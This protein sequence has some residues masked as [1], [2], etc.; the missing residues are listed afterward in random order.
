MPYLF[1]IG[2]A[3][4]LCLAEAQVFANRHSAQLTKISDQLCQIDLSQKQVESIGVQSG[5]IVKIA[6]IIN[7]DSSSPSEDI[8]ADL[9]K[10]AHKANFAVISPRQSIS[11]QSIKN[12][13]KAQNIS[14]RFLPVEDIYQTAFSLKS[15]YHEY[16]VIPD[17][18]KTIVAKVVWVQNIRHWAVRDLAR[19]YSDP[20]SGMLPPKIARIMINLGLSGDQPGIVFDPFCGSGTIV[21]EAAILGHQAIGS[22]ISKK[23][24][25]DSQNNLEWLLQKLNLTTKTKIFHQDVAHVTLDEIGAKPDAIVFEPFMGPPNIKPEKVK[26][27]VKGLEKLYLGAIKNLSKLQ[28]KGQ[29]MVCIFPL[30]KI[31]NIV[32]TTDSLID[33][34]EKFGYTL[35]IGPLEYSRPNATVIRRIYCL[36]KI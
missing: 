30:I 5:G 27:I 10:I 9:Q 19:P 31:N 14:S 36:E 4:E 28:S 1:L 25:E 15:N 22:D 35:K 32:K 3:K 8:V 6:H 17:Q 7:Q 34:C 26:D 13:L 23:A 18:T 16:W 11:T 29:K 20:K 12:H 24:V 2:K 21:A 33:S